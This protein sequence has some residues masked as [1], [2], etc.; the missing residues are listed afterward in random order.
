[1]AILRFLSALVLSC[2]FPNYKPV[3]LQTLLE[4][5]TTLLETLQKKFWWFFHLYDFSRHLPVKVEIIWSSLNV[6]ISRC[7]KAVSNNGKRNQTPKLL[8]VTFA[9]N[10]LSVI[11][12]VVSNTISVNQRRMNMLKNHVR[13]MS[14]IYDK[15]FFVKVI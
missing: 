8:L 6:F 11:W 5:S 4:P 15:A 13:T 12:I 10:C 1:M 3:F 14:N 9:C 7:S 2:H